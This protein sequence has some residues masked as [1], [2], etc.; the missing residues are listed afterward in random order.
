[1]LCPECD[2]SRFY[3]VQRVFEYHMIEEVKDGDVMLQHLQDA[4]VDTEFNPYLYCEECEAQFDL[5]LE[6]IETEDIAIED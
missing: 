6:E 2:S 4:V 5:D 1:M 3:Y